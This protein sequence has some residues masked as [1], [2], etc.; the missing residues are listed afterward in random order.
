M[1]E[2]L[3]NRLDI[4]KITEKQRALGKTI[5]TT[6]GAFDL[7]HSGHIKSLEFAKT[8]G[9]VLI[10]CL[11]SDKSIKEYKSNN[12]PILSQEDRI[13]VLSAICFV[14]YIVLFD[15]KTPVE[16]LG[17]IKPDVHVKGSEYENKVI[18]KE[19][20]ER[21]GGVITF[22]TRNPADISTT[23]II[24]KILKLNR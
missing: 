22:I 2:K 3:V 1:N 19:V 16:I 6:C 13:N 20:V 24:Q 23:K 10:V 14:D 9:D 7:L 18:E 15:E 4:K 12:R 8:K 5:V 17:E 11:N 21:F